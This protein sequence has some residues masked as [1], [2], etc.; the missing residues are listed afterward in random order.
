MNTFHELKCW[1]SY[2]DAILEGR[3]TFEVRKDDRPVLFRA[4][5]VL[6]L[7]EWIPGDERYTGR[8]CVCYVPYLMQ[9]AML[10]PEHVCMS[11][12]LIDTSYRKLEQA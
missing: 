2:F 7:R 1:P 8:E 11:I 9:N 4:G 5:D 12:K 3:K 6:V 10:A